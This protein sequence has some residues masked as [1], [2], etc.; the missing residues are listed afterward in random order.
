MEITK[1]QQVGSVV[2]ENYKTAQV[3]KN[4]GIDF[5]CGGKKSI[6]KACL[7]NNVELEQAL[8][9]LQKVVAGP[10][11][12]MPD[13]DSYGLDALT[14][15]II[16]NHHSYVRDNLPVLYEY[17]MKINSVHGSRH[18]ELEPV[19]NLFMQSAQGLLSHM[20]KEEQ[21]LFPYVKEMAKTKAKGGKVES[22]G[23]G[24]V[25]NPI[26]LM[27]DEH[28]TEG[29]RFA[30]IAKLTNNYMPPQDACNTYRV[31]FHKLRE[32]ENDL[33]L[34]VHLENN[35]LFPKA[36]ELERELSTNA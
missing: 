2:K 11:E 19:L 13:F 14:D 35:I 3:F 30:E 23:F 34:H 17:L 10:D 31:A 22:P 12:D 29:G 32:F 27:I 33:H 24:A 1:D 18:P 25:E 9:S 6:E 21:I 7:E 26:S 36:V 20:Q 5:C 16:E 15:H 28:E 8:Q 4:L